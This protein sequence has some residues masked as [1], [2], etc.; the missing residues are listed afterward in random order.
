M[1]RCVPACEPKIYLLDPIS[2][3][4]RCSAKCPDVAI[5]SAVSGYLE[6]IDECPEDYTFVEDRCTKLKS[7]QNLI[8]GLSVGGAVVIV[9]LI[10]VIVLVVKC[11]KNRVLINNGEVS[12]HNKKSRTK[13]RKT[14]TEKV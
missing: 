5:E 1:D 4:K 13:L 11:R 7:K 8:I 12:K 6:C 3:G 10:T 14:E 9:V 2:N